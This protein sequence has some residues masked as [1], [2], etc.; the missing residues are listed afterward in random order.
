MIAIFFINLEFDIITNFLKFRPIQNEKYTFGGN[1]IGFLSNFWIAIILNIFVILIFISG[2]MFYLHKYKRVDFW[3]K[4][5]M[6]SGLAGSFC[7]L[8]DKVFWGGSLDFI[9]IPQLFTFD[10]KDC[11]VT[12]VVVL[13]LVIGLK[14]PK[15]FD[16]KEYLL[17]CFTRK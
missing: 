11:Y 2:Y 7:S 16:L 10:L 5:T 4:S 8:I 3:A 1:Y 13:I 17:F 9:Q 15:D 12:F 14:Y 6:I